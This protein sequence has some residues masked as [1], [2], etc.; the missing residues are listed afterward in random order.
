MGMQVLTLRPAKEQTFAEEILSFATE[1][2]K[3]TMMQGWRCLVEHVSDPTRWMDLYDVARYTGQDALGWHECDAWSTA[4][5]EPVGRGWVHVVNPTR[6]K[7]LAERM[8]LEAYDP[9]LAAKAIKYDLLILLNDPYAIHLGKYYANERYILYLIS[10]EIHHYIQD[11]TGR[12]VVCDHVAP[13]NDTAVVET[14]EGF[15]QAVG[16]WD[17]FKQQYL[18]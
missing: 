6:R 13:S 5:D 12:Q 15:I 4:W 2:Y 1:K 18:I 11:W 9:A 3:A 8:E 17:A 7:Q 10:H 14:L 16:G